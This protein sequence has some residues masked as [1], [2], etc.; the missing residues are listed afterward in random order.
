ML[1]LGYLNLSPWDA[2]FK[3]SALWPT[4]NC[5][6]TQIMFRINFGSMVDLPKP[7][8]PIHL[9]SWDFCTPLEFDILLRRETVFLWSRCFDEF[10]ADVMSSANDE[11]S[12]P[13][14]RSNMPDERIW[15]TMFRN[16]KFLTSHDRL[17]SLLRSP[18]VILWVPAFLIPHLYVVCVTTATAIGRF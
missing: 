16:K 2:D 12:R 11:D 7:D 10:D 17:E 14:S 9:S 18:Q 8:P 1:P 6:R 3:T 13:D 5:R 4:W 15:H